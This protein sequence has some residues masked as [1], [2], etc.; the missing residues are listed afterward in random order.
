MRSERTLSMVEAKEQLAC[1]PE[2]FEQEMEEWHDIG[3]VAVTHHDKPVLAILPWELYESI[4]ETLEILSDEEPMVDMRQGI[5]DA[6]EG[7]GVPLEVV[8]KELGLLE[9]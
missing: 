3:V 1:L 6:L 8:E 7:K 5:K 9:P 2:M 4:M